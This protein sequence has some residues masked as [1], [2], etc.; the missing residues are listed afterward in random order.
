MG[1]PPIGLSGDV[2]ILYT[3]PSVFEISS[4]QSCLSQAKLQHGEDRYTQLM[5]A[6]GTTEA[7]EMLVHR[8]S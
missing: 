4:S 3:V 7:A 5:A 6:L 8:S 1:P 2:L